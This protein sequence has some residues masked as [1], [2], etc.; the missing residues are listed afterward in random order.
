LV[1]GFGLL[2]HFAAPLHGRRAACHALRAGGLSP[3]IL[4]SCS[5]PRPRRRSPR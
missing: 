5:T 4:S 3:M 1:I 2:L